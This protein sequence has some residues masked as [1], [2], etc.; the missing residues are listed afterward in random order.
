M[1]R[2]NHEKKCNFLQ[3]DVIIEFAQRSESESEEDE[4]EID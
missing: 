3:Q 1:H 4:D 2:K